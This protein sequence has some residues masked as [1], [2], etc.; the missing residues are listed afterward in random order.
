MALDGGKLTRRMSFV[1]TRSQLIHAI[2]YENDLLKK[3][4]E[5]KLVYDRAPKT[6]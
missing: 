2:H 1:P 6:R 5:L 3:P 4:L